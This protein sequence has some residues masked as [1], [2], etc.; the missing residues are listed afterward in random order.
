M[1]IDAQVRDALAAVRPKL[2]GWLHAATFPVAVVAGLTLVILAPT[3]MVRA[4]AALY[5]LTAALLFGISALYHRGHW[6]P[7][8][9]ASLK[10]LDHANIFLIIAGTYTPFTLLILPSESARVLLSLVWIGALLGVGFRVFWLSAPRWL[11]VPIYIALGWA[12][13]FWLPQFAAHGGAA[14]VALIIAG[15]LLYTA[16]AVV[17][18]VKRPNPWPRWFGFHEVFHAFTLAGFASHHVGIWLAAF[19]VGAVA[20]H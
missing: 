18:G 20:A 5:T 1:P 13:V 3:A 17:Y 4:S 6:S 14:V 9:A 15:G 7:R 12:A 16:G 11:Y 2:R 10:R 19:G 8:V